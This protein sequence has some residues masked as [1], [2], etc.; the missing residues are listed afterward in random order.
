MKTLKQIH[1]KCLECGDC[2][3]WQGATN[4]SG[5]P[6]FHSKTARRATWEAAKGPVPD[7]KLVTTTC[8]HAKCL[9]VGHLAL[10]TRAEVSKASNARPHVKAL[11]SA[12]TAKTVRAK[13][14]KIDMETARL[15]RASDKPGIELAAEYGVSP[16]HIS[17][18][19]CNISWKEASS[20]FAGLGARG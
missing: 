15:I 9:A 20:P 8:G 7:G 5:Q 17:H 18:V 4:G 10:T 6:K 2:M 16:S 14:G 11:R 3:I 13:L 1:A 12:S 19:R